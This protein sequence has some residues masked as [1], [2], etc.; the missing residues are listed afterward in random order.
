MRMPMSPNRP[1]TPAQQH[2][3]ILMSAGNTALFAAQTVG[4][5]RNTVANWLRSPAFREALAQGRAAQA[6]AWRDQNG[7]LAGHALGAIRAILADPKTPS[8]LRLKAVLAIRGLVAEPAPA[9]TPPLAPPPSGGP[10][11]NQPCPCGSGKKFKRC[12]LGSR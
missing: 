9:K 10:G 2:A 8:R 1:L 12:C 11:R 3:L 6:Q 5:H 4:V 7:A